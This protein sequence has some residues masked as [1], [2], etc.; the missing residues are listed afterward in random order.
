MSAD[1]GAKITVFADETA[2]PK[3]FHWGIGGLLQE[4]QGPEHYWVLTS[5]G[6][7]PLLRGLQ[8]KYCNS[9]F[10]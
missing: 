6:S 4:A 8:K 9:G 3:V 1:L 10:F 7:N 5:E 2:I